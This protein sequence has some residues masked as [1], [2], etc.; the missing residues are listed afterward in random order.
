MGLCISSVPSTAAFSYNG[1]VVPPPL[2]NLSKYTEYSIQITC[3][4]NVWI[5]DS[6]PWVTTECGLDFSIW[7][8][9]KWILTL[10]NHNSLF[11]SFPIP[12]ETPLNLKTE[13][14]QK[15]FLQESY[16]LAA[17]YEFSYTRITSRNMSKPQKRTHPFKC[18]GFHIQSLSAN[19]CEDNAL[20]TWPQSCW[21]KHNS[22]HP[23]GIGGCEFS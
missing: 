2:V 9:C 23:T 8:S 19:A 5:L 21:G 1:T 20:I 3:P 7:S 22:L 15:Y 13:V 6:T 10:F 12:A 11:P 14:G 16:Q 17:M 18:V 4:I